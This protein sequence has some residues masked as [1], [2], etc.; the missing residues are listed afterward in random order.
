M[1]RVK[2]YKAA[3]AIFTLSSKDADQDTDYSRLKHHSGNKWATILAD[4]GSLDVFIL[5]QEVGDWA[6][7]L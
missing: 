4:A 6:L 3:S 5:K 2:L 7:Q 1:S